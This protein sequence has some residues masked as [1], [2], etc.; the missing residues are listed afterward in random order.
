LT[1]PD[2]TEA[3]LGRLKGVSQWEIGRSAGGHPILAASWG[4]R[5]DLPNRTSASL[6]S[7]LSGGSAAAFYGEGQRQ[8]QVLLFVGNAHGIEFEGTVAAVNMLSVLA[9]G[10]D[11]RGRRW[12]RMQR[13]GRKL[14]VVVIPTLNV[15]GRMRHADVTHF[16]DADNSAYR[17]VSQGDWK[18]GEPITWPKSKLVF[19]IPPDKVKKMGGYFN[20]RGV[21]LVY[22]TNLGCEPQPETS[23]LLRLCREEMPDCAICSH[24]N[25]GSLVESPD[26]FIP[27]YFRQRQVQVAGAVGARALRDGI[28]RRYGFPQRTH[29]YAGETLYQTDLIYHACGALPLLVEFPVG[30][31]NFPYTFHELLDIGMG[32]L[33]EIICFGTAD[34]FRPQDPQKK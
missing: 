24:T 33:E 17:V 4:E 8:R 32:V 20:D 23:A 11:L 26:S 3:A 34:R 9:T 6:S 2:E 12:P 14:R 21:N 28:I 7:A 16:L 30:Y 31:K 13:E 5:E 25:R 27:S 19:P 18:T 10:K 29:S 15:D 22:D 1:L